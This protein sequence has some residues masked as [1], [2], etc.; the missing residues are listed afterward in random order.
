MF[1]NPVYEKA[2]DKNGG[3][4]VVTTYGYDSLGRLTR[5]VCDGYSYEYYY[6]EQGLL[7][8]KRSSGKRLIS[9]E[10]D[11]AGQ[12]I[13]MTNPE[14]ITVS[15]ED[16]RLGRMS[17]IYN[18]SGMEVRYEYDCLDRLEQ[19][20]YGNGIVT[21][22]QYDDSG[23]ISQLE[24]KAGDKILVSFRYEYDGNGNRTSK[25][26]EQKLV[27]GESSNLSVTY[28]YDVRGQLLEEN[29][30]GDACCYTYDA[31]GNRLQKASKE[32][33]TSYLYNEKN[34]LVSEE[35]NRG[36][37][38]FIYDPQGSIIKEGTWSNRSCRSRMMEHWT[39]V[40]GLFM[41]M[42]RWDGLLP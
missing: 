8:E 35:G 23:N 10:Y 33:L 24:T 42:I 1:G 22:Y 41:P 15:Y 18:S 3:N 21:R 16:D 6:N 32:E 17:R 25:I 14:G 2:T 11:N 30:N 4:A 19:I 38:T 31:A 28:Q 12:M 27:G 5:A 9:Y 40:Q 7:R 26:G 29:R 37:K 39:M 13:R 36:K 20:T 34:Q